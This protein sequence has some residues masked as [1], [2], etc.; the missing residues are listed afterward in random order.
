MLHR[1]RLFGVRRLWSAAN[2]VWK[3]EAMTAMHSDT[4]AGW[5]VVGCFAASFVLILLI[6]WLVC[7]T[8]AKEQG[9]PKWRHT[10]I[11]YDI[12]E[13]CDKQSCAPKGKIH[14]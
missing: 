13:V 9:P 6:Y 3:F 10:H 8:R 11:R 12:L 7:E 2:G 4:K 5:L 14:E 1:V